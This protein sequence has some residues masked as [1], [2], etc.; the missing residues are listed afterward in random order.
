M[1]EC[2]VQCDLTGQIADA[3]LSHLLVTTESAIDADET[4]KE[5]RT[6]LASRLWVCAMA[7]AK[8]A[9]AGLFLREEC[10]CPDV[11]SSEFIYPAIDVPKRGELSAMNKWWLSNPIGCKLATRVAK[12]FVQAAVITQSLDMA[13]FSANLLTAMIPYVAACIAEPNQKL[14]VLGTLTEL[15]TMFEDIALP[16]EVTLDALVGLPAAS[17]DASFFS[18]DADVADC[19][20]V[21]F[22]CWLRVCLERVV[23]DDGVTLQ[24]PTVLTSLLIQDGPLTAVQQGILTSCLQ[25][26]KL[27]MVQQQPPEYGRAALCI[28]T[29][30]VI[31]PVLHVLGNGGY[32][33]FGSHAANTDILALNLVFLLYN[34]LPDDHQRTAYLNITLPSLCGILQSMDHSSSPAQLCGKGITHIARSSPQIFRGEIMLLPEQSRVVLQNAMRAVLEAMN[35]SAAGQ[36]APQSAAT[37]HTQQTTHGGIKKIDMS[38]YRG[39]S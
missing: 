22:S 26:I 33:Q 31:P 7:L 23:K 13:V 1:A 20:R 4:T 37:G 5:D 29:S 35:Q 3:L 14:E 36:N 16:C 11:T 6:H 24:V 34:I 18:S 19:A 39:G 2:S 12:I 9:L 27:Y 32:S 30:S 21:L 25:A 28:V 15:M 17:G 38:K 8:I 10:N